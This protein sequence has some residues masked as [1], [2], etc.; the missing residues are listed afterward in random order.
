MPAASNI[1]INDGATTPVAHT[2]QPAGYL[3]NDKNTALFVE[4]T[5]GVLVGQNELQVY[6]RSNNSGATRKHQL[7]LTLPTVQT[8]TDVNGVSS[9]K[10]VY[11]ELG[12]VDFV[13]AANSTTQERKNLRVLLGNALLNSV[14]G[15]A[16]DNDETFW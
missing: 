12:S 11:V 15:Q 4:R 5:N 10:V 1:V 6:R 8:V 2:F 9:T 14:I 7:K 16:L 13:V 3:G